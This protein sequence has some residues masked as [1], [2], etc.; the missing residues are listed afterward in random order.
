MDIINNVKKILNEDIYLEISK[1]NVVNNTSNIYNIYNNSLNI[2]YI[3]KIFDITKNDTKK[4][5]GYNEF[6][7]YENLINSIRNIINIPILYGFIKNDN[8]QIY[9]LL[10]E[11]L[12][13]IKNKNTM[14]LSKDLSVNK[15]LFSQVL[16]KEN[17]KIIINNISK[18]HIFYW[19]KFETNIICGN[20]QYIIETKVKYETKY[21]FYNIPNVFEDNIYNIFNKLFLEKIEYNN[22]DNRTFIH[23]SLK[24][25]NIIL[26]NN[27]NEIIPYFI[28]WE[29]YKIG[30]GVEDIL[31]LLIFSLD[32]ELFKNNFDN[33]LQYYFVIINE[34]HQYKYENFINHIK[35]SLID[36]ILHE[37]VGLSIKNHFSNIKNNKINIYINNY[38]YL[39]DKYNILSN[40]KYFQ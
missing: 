6:Y 35:I 12:N 19:N 38:L 25:D 16:T 23:G 15:E 20:S 11:N 9:G 17:I 5:L 22:D 18:L 28:D 14:I 8:N 39:I 40:F 2:S 27:N 7:F 24:I 10:L 21:Y 29:L 33:L 1:L 13:G 26:V 37:I 30:Y 31:F 34:N 36:F 3:C 32:E 4:Y